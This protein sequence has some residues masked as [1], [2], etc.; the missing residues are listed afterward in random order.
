MRSIDTG[1]AEDFQ[2]TEM[3]DETSRTDSSP[4]SQGTDPHLA[5]LERLLTGAGYAPGGSEGTD[6]ARTSD[7]LYLIRSEGGTGTGTGFWELIGFR[8]AGFSR[9]LVGA[10]QFADQSR[11]P[12]RYARRSLGHYLSSPPQIIGL[13]RSTY[14]ADLIE[15]R[16]PRQGETLPDLLGQLKRGE[17]TGTLYVDADMVEI[18][19]DFRSEN[20]SIERPRLA[21][22][23]GQSL[24]L[25][26]LEGHVVAGMG[27]NISAKLRSNRQFL[28][29]TAVE[30]WLPGRTLPL[31]TLVIH[32]RYLAMVSEVAKGAVDAA[33]PAPFAR[34][35]LNPFH[36]L[37]P[38]LGV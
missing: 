5:Y 4:P 31:P 13:D 22:G 14:P 18:A 12:G 27:G 28:A 9:A 37:D 8:V 34:D 1:S 36:L 25:R 29:L 11:E 10:I 23:P 19:W 2:K 21:Q 35:S 26:S 32:R 20:P 16:V 6:G 38:R 15:L 7:F 17:S 3:T 24:L 33:V 30:Q